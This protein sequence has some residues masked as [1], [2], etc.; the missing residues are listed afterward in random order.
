M[1][2]PAAIVQG[3]RIIDCADCVMQQTVACDDCVVTFITNRDPGDALVIDVAEERAV[4]SLQKAGLVPDL[5]HVA[6]ETR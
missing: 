1:S 5:R 6:R 2:H 3:M 4:R